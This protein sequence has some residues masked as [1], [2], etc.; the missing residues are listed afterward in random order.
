MQTFALKEPF[1][2][3]V[4]PIAP[5]ALRAPTPLQLAP[6]RVSNALVATTVL[7][8]PFHGRVS[9][10]AEAITVRTALVPQRPAPT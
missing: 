8:A 4:L 10:A 3:L 9:I 2:L 1:P 6:L 7:R 5:S